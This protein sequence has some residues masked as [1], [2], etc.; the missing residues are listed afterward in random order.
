MMKIYLEVIMKSVSFL[1]ALLLTCSFMSGMERIRDS[2]IFE[3]N[4]GQT[5]EVPAQAVRKARI[6]NTIYQNHELLSFGTQGRITLS[7]PQFLQN[8]ELIQECI[9][10]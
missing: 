7:L 5:V 2:I 6:F 4:K 1:G 3:N 9:D 10:Y 8:V